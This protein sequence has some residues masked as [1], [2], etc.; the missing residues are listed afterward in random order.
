[1]KDKRLP[2]EMREKLKQPIGRLML[3]KEAIEN[4]RGR[5]VVSV[6][7]KV[8]HTLLSNGITPN[9][10]IYDTI[11]MR[12]PVELTIKEEID[13]FEAEKIKTRNPP[14][15]ITGEAFEVVEKAIKS[16]KKIKIEVEGEED[17]LTLP[18][19]LASQNGGVV[20]YGQPN[21][22][23]VCVLVSEE[24]KRKVREFYDRMSSSI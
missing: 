20:F 5:F 7:D 17:L 24:K 19:I 1:M 11:N 15:M 14:G 21:Q 9:V 23:I 2:V 12:T 8:S 22:G 18:A 13:R 6:G 4:T 16:G 3:E 10:V